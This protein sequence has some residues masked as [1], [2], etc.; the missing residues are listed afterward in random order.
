MMKKKN[1]QWTLYSKDGS[2]KLS[3]GSLKKVMSDDF[4]MKSKTKGTLVG[5]PEESKPKP[6]TKKKKVKVKEDEE[7]SVTKPTPITG[8]Y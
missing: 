1:G 8:V 2:K 7:E 5:N 6:A 4:R 3:T